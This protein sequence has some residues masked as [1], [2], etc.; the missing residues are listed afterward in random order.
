MG[1]PGDKKIIMRDVIGI[2]VVAIAFIIV[3]NSANAEGLQLG[4]CKE[5]WGDIMLHS[6]HT[7]R[8]SNYNEDNL[9]V[10]G[11]CVFNNKWRAVAGVYKNSLDVTTD[12]V[13][14]SYIWKD[15]GYWKFTTALVL[16][17]G[18]QNN[19]KSWSP[20]PIP[21]PILAYEAKTWG[22]NIPIIPP[23]FGDTGVIA[24]QLKFKF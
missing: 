21:V 11:E 13:G 15:W 3:A 10:G 4:I 8:N 24:I 19:P 20:I 5:V 2:I 22:I 1:T 12:Y 9:G 17:T 16:A 18:Y 14:I 6:Y 23:G 7:N